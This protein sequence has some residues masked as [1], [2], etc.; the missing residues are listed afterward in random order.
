[1]R[2]L[3]ALLLALAWIPAACGGGPEP[4]DPQELQAAVMDADR[5]FNQAT[6]ERGVEGWVSFFADDG[7][8]IGEGMGEIRGT[9][10]IREAVAYLSDPAF[11]LTWEPIRADVAASGDLGYTV[12]QYTS[13]TEG[14][15]GQVT[16]GQGLYVS[17]WRLQADGRWKVVM[18]LGNPTDDPEDS[19]TD[20]G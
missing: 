5:A 4:A 10:A 20:E 17:I 15:D 9:D 18:D 7:A 19:N 16:V 6:Q 1:M 3:P 12:G 8:L 2:K 14:E 13:R 11:S